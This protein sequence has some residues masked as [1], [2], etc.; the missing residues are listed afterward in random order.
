MV[1]PYMLHEV[2]NNRDPI[3]NMRLPMAG[4]LY[5]RW[6][7]QW[8]GPYIQHEVTNNWT[9]YTTRGYQWLDSICNMMLSM[10]WLYLQHEVSKGR[11]PIFNM[12]LPMVGSL[13]VT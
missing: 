6:G 9:L 4:S 7:Y 2:T 8:L 3:C 1:G 13:Y 10:V 5:V 11:Y 12:R